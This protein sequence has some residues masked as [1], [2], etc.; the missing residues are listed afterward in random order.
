[1]VENEIVIELKVVESLLKIH[2]A[3]VLTYLKLS[4]KTAGLLINFQVPVLKDGIKRIVNNY[5]D[6]SLKSNLS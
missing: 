4:G 5:K 6:S 3:Q 2:E 1:V